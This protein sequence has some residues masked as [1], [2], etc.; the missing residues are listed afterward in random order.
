MTEPE[1][2]RI[3][4]RRNLFHL[5]AGCVLAVGAVVSWCVTYVIALCLGYLLEEAVAFVFPRAVITD[6]IATVVTAIVLIVVDV[7]GFT[8]E[9]GALDLSGWVDSSANLGTARSS[10]SWATVNAM[11]RYSGQAYVLVEILLFAAIAT[12]EAI[13]M[14][15]AYIRTTPE[16]RADAARIVREL[17]EAS[18][19]VPRGRY[20]E[21][22]DA[23]E[24]LHH[25]QL[26]RQTTR[27]GIPSIRTPLSSQ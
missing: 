16:T 18:D 2:H 6:W 13:A 8:R 14:F 12:R 23:V 7:V 10:G 26:I 3:I 5:L 11:N 27:Q 25:L 17:R 21:S 1:L 4:V 22:L 15:R 9:H 19:W 20:H 24:L